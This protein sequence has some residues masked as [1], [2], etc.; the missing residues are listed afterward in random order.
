MYKLNFPHFSLGAEGEWR[1]GGADETRCVKTRDVNSGGKVEMQKKTDSRAPFWR[2]VFLA[3]Q[4][5]ISG[6]YVNLHFKSQPNIS[7]VKK[8]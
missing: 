2:T 3:K 6:D 7:L 1:L 4:Y 5:P 8:K